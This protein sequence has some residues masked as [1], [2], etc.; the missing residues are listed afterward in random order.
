MAQ[1]LERA[2]QVVS[3]TDTIEYDVNTIARQVANG[4]HEID[5]VVI[6]RGCA[7]AGHHFA[8]GSGGRSVHFHTDKPSQLEQGCAYAARS[9]VDQHALARFDPRGATHH[10]VRRDVVEDHDESFCRVEPR[11]NG[12][13]FLLRQAT[14]L[15]VPTRYWQ[16]SN[17]L[18]WF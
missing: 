17:H 4:F 5:V 11:R 8:L 15:G 2:P 6:D 16:G 7:Q 10:L 12:N 9:G 3:T 18:P 14:K 1:A 13:Q